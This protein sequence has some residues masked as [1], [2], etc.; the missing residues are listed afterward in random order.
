M[1]PRRSPWPLFG[2]L[3][4]ALLIL[5][6][7]LGRFAHPM[8][9]DFFYALRDNS[10]GVWQAAAHEYTHWNGRYASNFLM[11]IGPMRLGFEG[12]DLYRAVPAALLALSVGAAFFFLRSAAGTTLKPHE[13]L[14]AALVWAVLFAHLMPDMP[15][16]IYWY[17]GSVTYQLPAALTLIAIGLLIRAK[18]S[19][20]AWATAIALPLLFFI[21]GCNETIMCLLVVAAACTVSRSL[22]FRKRAGRLAWAAFITIA[23]G[24]VL[25]FIAPGNG[26]R[27]TLYPDN[28]RLLQSLGMSALQ[29]A[30][31]SLTWMSCP[32]LLLLSIIWWMNHRHLSERFPLIASGF[33]LFPWMSVSALFGVVF[34]CVFPPYWSTGLLGQHRTLNTACFFFLP[35]WFVNLSVFAAR[36]GGTVVRLHDTDR[37][38][39]TAA[40]LLLVALDFGFTGNSGNAIDDLVTGRA[41]RS[42]EQLWHRYRLL[43]WADRASQDTASVPLIQDPPKSL[44]VLDLREPAFLVNTD[45]AAWFGLKEVRIAPAAQSDEAKATN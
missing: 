18:R 3:C 12:I 42:N 4:S 30:R 43:R 26:G 13:A 23:I 45:Y 7:Y 15:E 14:I 31:F 16:G 44:Y 37:R 36:F 10:N 29:T 24:A 6:A 27:E 41:Q 38:R 34:L 32:A 40:L 35:L 28:H 8:A 2:I 11:L 21:T 25:V 39:A 17:T 9:D 19:G 20:A 22:I 33:G 1:D 5:H